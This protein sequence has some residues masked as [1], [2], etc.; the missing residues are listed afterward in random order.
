M[1]ERFARQLMHRIMP[2]GPIYLGSHRALVQSIFGPSFYV[3][4]RDRSVGYALLTSGHW[5]F[6]LTQLL[7]KIVRRGAVVV[8]VGA[9]L[10]WHTVMVAFCVGPTGRVIAFE[11]NPDMTALLG[12]NVQINNVTERVE[13]VQ[14]AVYSHTGT[15]QFQVYGELMGGSSVYGNIGNATHFHDTIRA[16]EVSSIR[17]DDQFPP[18]SKVDLIHADVEGAEPHVVRGARRLI[19]DNPDIALLLEYSPIM[20][21]GS[22]ISVREFNDE[23]QQLGFRPYQL[24]AG[25]QVALT[26]FEALET[27]GHCDILLRR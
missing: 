24:K 2:R 12:R 8:D 16:I 22:G 18:G 5:E 23:L 15:L 20:L 4:T 14:K 21:A 11:A 17:L 6:D 1:I 9:N 7:R 27:G 10:G 25:G 19:G 13:I 26:T 3:D